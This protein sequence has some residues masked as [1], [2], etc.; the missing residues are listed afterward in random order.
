MPKTRLVRT[1][2]RA[3]FA[4]LGW[5]LALGGWLLAAPAVP[6]SAAAT[7]HVAS[8]ADSGATTLRGMIG[9]AGGGTRSSSI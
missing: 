7:L 9:L 1:P 3:L 2:R 6:V 8:C 5:L 4:V